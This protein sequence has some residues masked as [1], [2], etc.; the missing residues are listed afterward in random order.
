MRRLQQWG[1]GLCLAFAVTWPAQAQEFFDETFG[2]LQ[3]ELSV[4]KEADKKGI[5]LFFQ[6]EECPFCDRMKKTIL[7]QPDVIDYFREHFLTYQIDIEGSNYMVNFDG[8]EGTSQDL[9]EKIYRVRATP[10]MIIFDLEGQPLVRYTGPT[11][12]KKEF[13]LLGQYV[14]DGVYKDMSFTRYKRSQK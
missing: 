8:Q 9:S 12:S 11:R 4:A 5:F 2:D 13:K 3:E 7:N 1:V 6:M 14:V 10:V